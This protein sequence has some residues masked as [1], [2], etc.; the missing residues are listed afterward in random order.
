YEAPPSARVPQ[1][2]TRFIAWFND[3]RNM[4]GVVRAG[5]AHLWFACIH[6]FSDGNGRV[7]RAIAEKALSQEVGASATLSLSTACERPRR[8]EHHRMD[9]LVHGTCAGG[10][11]SDQGADW[12]YARKDAFLGQV[13]KTAERASDEGDRANAARGPGGVQGR[14]ERAEIHEDHGLLEGHG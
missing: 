7:G 8:Y 1:E 13:C 5:V 6:P 3:S 4:P 9:G 10:A 14:H 2:M 12:L 11:G